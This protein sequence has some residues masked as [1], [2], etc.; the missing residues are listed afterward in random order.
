MHLKTIGGLWIEGGPAPPSLAPRQLAL[1]ALVAAAGKKG[2][3]RD[4][5]IGILWPETGE[6]QARHSLS[7][8]LYALRRDVGDEVIVGATHLRLAPS[9]TSDI[10]EL[11]SAWVAGDLESVANLFTGDFLDGFYVPG[12][13]EFERWVEEE[14]SAVALEGRRALE[15]LAR[16]A[17]ES[18]RPGDAVR[19]WHRLAGLDPLSA[20]YAASHMRALAA[21]GDR[22]GAL[23][24][25]RA[26]QEA[27]HREL[28]AAPDPVVVRLAQSL[29]AAPADLGHAQPAPAPAPV[30]GAP[31]PSSAAPVPS[32]PVMELA[33]PAARVARWLIPVSLLIVAAIALVARGFG[34]HSAGQRPFLAVGEIHPE[35]G[36]DSTATDRVLRDM[37]ATSLAGVEGLQVVANSRLVELMPR[38]ADTARGATSDAARRAGATE[39]I[40]GELARDAAGLVLSLRRVALQRG[41]VRRGYVVRARDRYAIVDSAAA[42][43]ARDLNFTPPLTTVAES[44]TA[45][46]AAYALYDE[47][48]RAY[49]GYDA[50]AAY[51]LMKAAVARDS[52]FAMAAYYVWQLGRAYEPE[53]TWTRAIH[54]AE[55][56]ALRTIEPERLLI[57][58]SVAELEAPLQS[59][60][61]IAETLTV[62]YPTLPEGHLLLG[63][64]RGRQGDWA[65]SVSAYH[66][67]FALDSAAGALASPSCRICTAIGGMAESYIWWD[68]VGAAERWGRKLIA[69]R[70]QEPQTWSNLIEPLLR[71][72][73]RAEAEAAFSQSVRSS[74]PDAWPGQLERDLL[75]W[76]RYEEADRQLIEAIASR[77]ADI[78]GDASWLLLLSLRDQGRLLEAD[79]MIHLWRIPNTTQAIPHPDADPIDLAMLS[80]EMGRPQPSIRVFRENATRT[81]KSPVLPA[82]RARHLVWNL[83][84]AGTAYAAAGDTAVVRRLADSLELLGPGS[85]FGRDGR[86]HYVLRGLLL[87]REGRHAEAVDAFRR[88]L[89][90]LTDGYTRTNLMMARS[91]LALGRNAEAI[92]VLQPAIRGGVDGSNTYVSRTELHEAL[93][94]AFEQAGRRDSAMVHW[95]A[96]ESAWRHAD[97]QF[98]ERY[99]RARLKSGLQ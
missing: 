88:S 30:A 8:T 87:Q 53:S 56:L 33:K 42:A 36:G 96:V 48:L 20:P 62:K 83:T 80:V 4:R 22:S 97:L 29:R 84:L 58:G 23:A 71:Q 32:A 77:S 74:N 26:Y 64:V 1:L 61:A 49:F 47:G 65:G 28:N 21:A 68:S 46:P 98:R 93:A 99:L 15:R 95:R 18:G 7:Q 72:G 78:R 25:A 13:P 51:R 43:I 94:Q 44:R 24:R 9:V 59:A 76:G 82:S 75:R 34:S 89:F 54:R 85:N 73:R 79:S 17:D 66:R 63:V 40:E 90:S 60:V 2:V 70:P 55:A 27:V 31:S 19:W 16:H 12:A 92:A 37:L 57:Q 91:L 14:R 38:G 81:A 67:A 5:A 3:T 10:G 50:P 45:S 6:D 35:N 39:V 52:D 41:V 69:Q 11:R 86:L